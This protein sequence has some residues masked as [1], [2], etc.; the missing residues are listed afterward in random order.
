MTRWAKFGTA[1]DTVAHVDDDGKVSVR[2]P[3]R[4]PSPRFPDR[5]RARARALAVPGDGPGVGLHQRGPRQCDRRSDPRQAAAA[6]HP[7][8]A[9]LHGRRVPPPRV[10]RRDRDPAAAEEVER[11]L[12]DPPPTSAR[13][14]STRCSRAPSTSTTGP[15]SG[16]TCCSS[17]AEHSARAMSA[18]STAGSGRREVQHAV[19]QVR[20]PSS[21]RRAAPLRTA[22]RIT[23]CSTG[24]DRPDRELHAGLP[25]PVAHLRPLP[26]PPDGEVDAERVLRLRE[27]LRARVGERRRD[28]R[29][30][31]R[32]ATVFST[33]DGDMLHPRLGI[34][35]P[36]RPLDGTP[37]PAHSTEDR[38]EYLADWRRAR[39]TRSSPARSST[40]SGRTSSAVAW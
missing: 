20:P 16:R 29:G 12:A 26:Q 17:R 34:A 39:R 11:F 2:G 18:I 27:P 21:R 6:P 4:R 38:R 5:R 9:A 1:D 30:E 31:E 33:P 25:R 40:A 14:S 37:M 10:S 7:A 35:L 28:V 8:V 15:T 32:T 19:G 23:S 24:P 36:P 22:R 3:A 13:S